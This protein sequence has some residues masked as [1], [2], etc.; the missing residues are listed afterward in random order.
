MVSVGLVSFTTLNQQAR[1]TI[2]VGTCNSINKQHIS[3]GLL[4]VSEQRFEH[5]EKQYV[6]NGQNRHHNQ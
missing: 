4:S 6:C 5:Q 3:I 2:K 1:K